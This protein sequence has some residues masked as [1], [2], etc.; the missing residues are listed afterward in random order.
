MIG[1]Y[2]LSR[3]CVNV[4]VSETRRPASCQVTERKKPEPTG[5]CKCR[6]D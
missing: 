6:D 3:G 5:K 2:A 1:G 4:W